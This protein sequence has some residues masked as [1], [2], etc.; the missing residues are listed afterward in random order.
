MQLS[1]NSVTSTSKTNFLDSA[2]WNLLTNFK[3]CNV[4]NAQ[5]L[6]EN[7]LT[8]VLSW[9]NVKAPAIVNSLRRLKCDNFLKTYRFSQDVPEPKL[10]P[11]SCSIGQG[12]DAL[13]RLKESFKK[14][15]AIEYNDLLTRLLDKKISEVY[16]NKFLSAFS[17]NVKKVAGKKI[18][19]ANKFSFMDLTDW[20]VQKIYLDYSS[21][22]GGWQLN[23][24][25]LSKEFVAE[26]SETRDKAF[27]LYVS[28]L[29][30]MTRNGQLKRDHS[31]NGLTFYSKGERFEN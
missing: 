30:R 22:S 26:E 5:D 29:E 31:Q 13:N 10:F 8:S 24:F 27:L 17:L 19:L 28:V 3:T 12:I 7:N 14:Q 16:L 6:S 15:D 20:A 21:K 2:C 18:V 9:A 4:N 23:A 25:T 1:Y 11:R